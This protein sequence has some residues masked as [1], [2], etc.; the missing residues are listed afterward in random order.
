M[1]KPI[2]GAPCR[3]CTHAERAVIDVALVEGR[4]KTA[5]AVRFGV[6]I[7]SL[8][9]HF[10]NHLP[11]A[12]RAAILTTK[13]DY[14]ATNLEELR[15][16]ESEGLLA[17]AVEVR[18][19]LYVNAE[20]AEQAGDFRA[21]TQSYSKILDALNLVGKL[22]N[23]FAGHHAQQVNQLV[24]SPDYLRLRAA[25]IQALAPFPEARVAVAK[26]LRELETVEIEG[27][28]DGAA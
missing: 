21:A 10:Y 2:K 20:A 8:W 7:H 28:S 26:V 15:V 12:V 17:N 24:V 23:Q 13:K 9:R 16:N 4:S 27:A 25:L 6:S 5:M 11:P 19:R 3:V 22:L 14:S 1:T 18:R